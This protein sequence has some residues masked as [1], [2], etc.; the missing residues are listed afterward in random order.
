MR[1]K[2]QV[3]VIDNYDLA[4]HRERERRP[5]EALPHS[6]A[7]PVVFSP[8]RNATQQR[9]WID[10]TTLSL[11]EHDAAEFLCKSRDRPAL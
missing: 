6:L 5:S 10:A 2:G 4:V 9:Q 3:L 11:K 1:A 7:R 8:T